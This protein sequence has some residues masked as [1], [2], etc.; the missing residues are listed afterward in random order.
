MDYINNLG[1]SFDVSTTAATGRTA[2]GRQ[3]ARAR[4]A[5][6]R[7]IMTDGAPTLDRAKTTEAIDKTYRQ[8][9]EETVRLGGTASDAVAKMKQK[10]EEYGII[11]NSTDQLQESFNQNL[12]GFYNTALTSQQRAALINA[13]TLGSTDAQGNFNLSQQGQNLVN[14]AELQ[15]ARQNIQDITNAQNNLSDAMQESAQRAN[16]FTRQ[17]DSGLNDAAEAEN[18]LS[19][20]AEEATQDLREQNEST[21]AMNNSFDNMKSAVKTF[22]SIG[23]AIGGLRQI[24]GQ[25]F[26]DIKELD[27]SFAEIAMVTDYTVS[28]MWSS[29]DKYATMAN[30]LGQ[31]TKSVIQA[32]GLFYQQGNKSVMII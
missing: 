16:D 26:N 19:R 2:L 1:Y 13:Q 30:E 3:D 22:F 9:L 31:S 14:N 18:R 5:S 25:T 10:L 29:Y 7:L 27:K 6:G 21:T 23:S 4:N 8:S 20:E 32:S 11:L 17:M 24:I 15:A 12:Q 28:E